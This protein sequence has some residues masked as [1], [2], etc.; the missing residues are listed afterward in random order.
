MLYWPV[1]LLFLSLF[2]LK[3]RDRVYL[4]YACAWATVFLLVLLIYLHEYRRPANHPDLFSFL[5]MPLQFVAY[6]LTYIGRPLS[7][8]GAADI[9]AVVF[10]A[11][12]IAVTPFA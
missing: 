7:Y 9:T 3:T 11:F 4:R 12:G 10:G 2:A 6:V 1:I 5:S 8:H